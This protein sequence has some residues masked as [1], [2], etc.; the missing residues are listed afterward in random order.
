MTETRASKASSATRAILGDEVIERERKTARLN[1]A[2]LERE[3]ADAALLPPEP[4]AK[5]RRRAAT[6]LKGQLRP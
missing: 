4:V 5:P 2:C 1:I 6:A 3:L